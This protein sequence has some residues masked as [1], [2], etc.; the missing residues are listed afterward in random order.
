MF[1]RYRPGGEKTGLLNLWFFAVESM[2]LLYRA[3]LSGPCSSRRTAE[4]AAGFADVILPGPL[5]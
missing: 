4:P 1:V 5:Q 2:E 3:T